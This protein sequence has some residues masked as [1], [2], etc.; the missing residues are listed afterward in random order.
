MTEEEAKDWILGRPDVSRETFGRLT[1]FVSIL[2]EESERQ[3]LIAQSTLA[4]VWNRHIA[5]SVQLLDH[6][7]QPN[8]SGPTLD[9]GS[10]AGLPGLVLAIVRSDLN[11][12]LVESR[13]LR[14]EFLDSTATQLG[15]TNVTVVRANLKAVPP[16]EASVITARAFAPLRELLDMA[17]GFSGA[18]T[19]WVLPRGAKGVREWQ[20]L[21]RRH[22]EMFHVEQSVTDDEAVILIGKGA[23]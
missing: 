5:D 6:F 8:D 4:T 22:K 14:C 1:Q 11:F 18:E 16:F 9:L 17:R 12:R 15:L 13:K 2:M 20:D 7:D 21:P 3:N 10:G 19:C 23:A